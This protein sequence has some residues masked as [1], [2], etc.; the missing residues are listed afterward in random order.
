MR[1]SDHGVGAA[2]TYPE[3][4]ER[5]PRNLPTFRKFPMTREADA[6]D[7]SSIGDGRAI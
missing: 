4:A 6:F 3:Y 1:V 5:V 7:I 2:K